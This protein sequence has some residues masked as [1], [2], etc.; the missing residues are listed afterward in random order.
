MLLQSAFRLFL[1][2]RES[3]CSKKTL[4]YYRDN[5]YKF[6]VFLS[7]QLSCAS[8]RIDCNQISRDLVV[9]YI[10]FLRNGD[11]K[12]TSVNTYFRAVKVFLNYCIDEGYCS[13]DVLRKIKFLKNDASSVVPL[14]G[15]EVDLIDGLYNCKTESGLRNLCIIHLMLDAG[16]RSS[17]VV[18]LMYSNINFDSNYL[19]IKGK[20]EKFRT[21]LLC[22]KLKKMLYHYFYFSS[23]IDWIYGGNDVPFFAKVGSQDPINEN[24]IKQLFARIKKKS[25]IDRVHPHLLRHTFATSYMVGGGNLEF[26][27]LMLGHS[28]YE[29]TKIYLHLANESKMLHIDIYKLDPVFFKSGY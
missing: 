8:D 9:A 22:P 19:M 21:V 3:Y 12:N 7:G 29:T 10:S 17:E 6:F 18:G 16:L 14:S 26:L 20:G 4:N 11:I 1:V 24:V 2:D 15:S 25:G 23:K 28:D 5:N 13:P 27:R